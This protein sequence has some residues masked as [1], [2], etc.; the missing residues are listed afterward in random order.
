MEE[1]RRRQ[2]L[3]MIQGRRRRGLRIGRVMAE[4]KAS[5][6]MNSTKRKS[7]RRTDL[8]LF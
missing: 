7:R 8:Y 4:M 5:M 6:G 2:R 1:K 3:M